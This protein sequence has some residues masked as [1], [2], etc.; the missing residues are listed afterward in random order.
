MYKNL[1]VVCPYSTL[2]TS[3]FCSIVSAER[4]LLSGTLYLSQLG[5]PSCP[6]NVQLLIRYQ[7]FCYSGHVRTAYNPGA[8]TLISLFLSYTYTALL[9]HFRQMSSLEYFVP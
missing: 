8:V 7:D 9:L 6:E 1:C 3:L 2:N 5:L 4:P